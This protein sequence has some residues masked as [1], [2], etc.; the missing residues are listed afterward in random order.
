M[1][2]HFLMGS[3]PFWTNLA[4]ETLRAGGERHKRKS[5]KG[6]FSMVQLPYDQGSLMDISCMEIPAG[7]LP[8]GE[9][10][11]KEE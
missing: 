5:P 9:A 3:T 2:D 8:Y 4:E 7:Q 6:N 1:G 11:R 10:S